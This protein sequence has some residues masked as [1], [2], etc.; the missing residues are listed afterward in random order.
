M[1]PPSLSQ[2]PVLAFLTDFGSTDGYAGIMKGVVLT[3]TSDVHLVDLSHEVPPQQVAAGAWVLSTCYHYFPP[4]TIFVCVVDPGVGSARR[5]IA[6]H[7]GNWFFVGPDNG[8]FS[9]VLADQPVHEAVVLANSAY[10]L[11]QVSTTFHGR[12]VFSPVA[13]HLASG[14]SLSA[15]GPRVEASSLQRLDTGLPIHENGQITAHIVHIDHFGNLITNIPFSMVPDLFS[16]SLVRLTFPAQ[17]VV[18]TERRRFFATS[19]PEAEAIRRP[20]LYSN[21]SGYIAVAVQNGNAAQSLGVE[22]GDTLY[23]QIK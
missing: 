19:S 18:V 17:N 4:G 1:L 8:L 10:H 5:P 6:L 20:F 15:F 21:S 2:R 16:S 9:Y 23:C 12:D 7:A 14:V 3:I 11:P 22:Y 13:A